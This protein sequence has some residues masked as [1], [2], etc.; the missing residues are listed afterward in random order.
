M[1]RNFVS[2]AQTA[3]K[4][5]ASQIDVKVCPKASDIIGRD[6]DLSPEEL[7]LAHVK[8]I[9]GPVQISLTKQVPDPFLKDEI[10]ISLIS[11]YI[12]LRY[13]YRFAASACE[14]LSVRVAETCQGQGFYKPYFS[15]N[16]S[17]CDSLAIESIDIFAQNVGRYA[18]LKYGFK[19][20]P[21][22]WG[23]MKYYLRAA[24][25]DVKDG[26]SSQ[27]IETAQKALLSDDPKAAWMI[28]D[29][30]EPCLGERLGPYLMSL[31]APWEGALDLTD[32]DC[33]RRCEDYLKQPV[34]QAQA[35]AF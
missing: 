31:T 8:N 20:S 11:E 10:K 17:L 5:L 12:D 24:F 27:S 1:S 19:P 16:L 2:R 15:N 7:A 14:L 25:N 26:L 30:D 21:E 9:S 34:P 35:A 4:T 22:S 3:G 13:K 23:D 6:T 28:A 18:W 32:D 33:R 29:L